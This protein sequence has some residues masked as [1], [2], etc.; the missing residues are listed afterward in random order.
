MALPEYLTERADG[1]IVIAG[2]R[3]G[4]EHVVGYYT[5]GYSPEMLVEQ[6]PTL[7]LAVVHKVIAYYLENHAGVDAYVAGVRAQ[8]NDQRA[9]G[10]HPDLAELRRRLE[11][12]PQARIANAVSA[13]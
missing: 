2:H 7:P 4:L 9:A 5:E 12:Q 11:A 13:R 10:M 8:L 1:A 3:I 6:F